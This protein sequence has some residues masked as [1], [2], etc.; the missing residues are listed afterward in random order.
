M[1]QDKPEELRQERYADVWDAL[2]DTPEAAADMRLRS[3]LMISI[4]QQVAG[5][6]LTQTAAAA[7][8]GIT[9]P[10]L[11]DLLRGK[12]GKFSLGA[13]VDLAAR[14]GLQVRVEVDQVAA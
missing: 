7:R 13:L 10:R 5:W 11:N 3:E 12:V 1:M 9:Q 14:A 4:Q 6:G 8:L 2:E